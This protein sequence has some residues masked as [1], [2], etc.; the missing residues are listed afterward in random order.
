MQNFLIA[1]DKYVYINST[2]AEAYIP[3]SLVGDIEE[4]HSSICYEYGEGFMTLGV[5]YIAFIDENNKSTLKTL[6]Y[7]NIIETQPSSNTVSTLNIAGVEDRYRVLQYNKGDILM[8]VQSKQSPDNCEMFMRL[9]TSGKIP[10]A[11]TY[12]D[13][14]DAWLANFNINGL[15]PDVPS[16]VLQTIVS[17]MCRDKNDLNKEFRFVA[18]KGNYDPHGYK[19][20]NMNA[21]SANSSVM[22]SL[23]FERYGEKLATAINMTKEGTKQKISPIEKVI[24]M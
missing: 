7:P 13:I 3:E 21:V 19:A 8:P 1:D 14:F 10:K 20:M 11:L 5:M 17:T 6:M 2:Y 15:H 22:S 9:I 4:N 24:T 16:V 18:G 12:T 23:S